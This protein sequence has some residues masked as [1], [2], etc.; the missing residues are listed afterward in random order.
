[1]NS[2][3]RENLL[4]LLAA[5][6]IP[7]G[8]LEAFFEW[9]GNA[10]INEIMEE[11]LKARSR[12]STH[13]LRSKR[14]VTRPSRQFQDFQNL[15]NDIYKLADQSGLSITEAGETISIELMRGWPEIE[16][17]SLTYDGKLGLKRWLSRMAKLVGPNNLLK[18]SLKALNDPDG[19]RQLDWSLSS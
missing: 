12:I 8:E 1:M 19:R 18:A 11:V 13:S 3:Q 7:L 15:V 2:R 6:R 17:S 5:S 4:Y 14:S 10:D 16:E 9:V